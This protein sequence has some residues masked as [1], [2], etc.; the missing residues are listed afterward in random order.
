MNLNIRLPPLHEIDNIVVRNNYKIRSLQQGKY[1]SHDKIKY[2][3]KIC[4]PCPSWK[5]KS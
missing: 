5:F 4:N 3:C 1:C 2:G